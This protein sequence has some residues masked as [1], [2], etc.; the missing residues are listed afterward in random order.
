MCSFPFS[1][2]SLCVCLYSS[3][4]QLSLCKICNSIATESKLERHF[5][6]LQAGLKLHSPG[7]RFVES[8]QYAKSLPSGAN[9]GVGCLHWWREAAAHTPTRLILFK[10]I[11]NA[12]R[13]LVWAVNKANLDGGL[14]Q[15]KLET[16]ALKAKRPGFTDDR[17]SETSYYVENGKCYLLSKCLFNK[18][19][20]NQLKS[21]PQVCG[22]FTPTTSPSPRSQR[23]VGSEKRF[24]TSL[25]ASSGLTQSRSM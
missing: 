1:S 3:E 25:P 23:A 15:A 22:K 5:P 4:L 11:L 18:W 8:C 7:G 13:C 24:S 19:Y 20:I 14:F 10:F 9:W 2:P 12:E 17:Y 6:L 16:K 21:N